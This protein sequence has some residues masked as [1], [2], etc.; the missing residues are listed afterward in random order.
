MFHSST[1]R[2]F[3]WALG[4]LLFASAGTLAAQG[5]TGQANFGTYVALG[6]S[7]TA[8]FMSGGLLDAVQANSYPALIHRQATGAG[9][10]QQP[11][12]AAPG[13]PP[14]LDLVRL[15]PTVIAPRAAS[16]GPPTN[17]T[18]P[19]PYSNLAIPGFKVGEVLRVRR[20]SDNGNRLV[21][22]I[23]RN[24][25]PAFG[26][27]TMLQQA[28]A[29]RPTFVSLWI[30]NNDV[31]GAATS[32]I[33]I[34]GVTLTPVAQ[35]DADY[36]A[37][38][39][40][41][42]AAG[43][44]LVLATIPNVTSIP[45]VTTIPSIL[46]N[47][48]TNQPVLVNGQPVPLIGPNGPLTAADRVLL[49]ATTPLSQGIGIPRAAGGSGKPLPTQFFLDAAEQQAIASRVA[50]YNDIIRSVASANGAALVDINALFSNIA[51]RGVGFGGIS[52]TA[53]FLTGGIFS[54]DGVHPTPFGYAFLANEFIKAINR[55][56][57][58]R[59]AQVDLFPFT[60][61]SEGSA[62]TLTDF[63]AAGALFSNKAAESLRQGLN[64]P[65]TEVLL[66]RLNQRPNRPAG[67]APAPGPGADD[68]PRPA[69][70][71]E[72]GLE[73]EILDRQ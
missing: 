55:Q 10:F 21:D 67:P 72:T 36:R 7:L 47:P 61:G 59:I 65:P 50:A 28:I 42:R 31:L 34:D 26:N 17:L 19:R 12:F 33:V 66:A 45:F 15:L 56:Y 2:L 64:V 58:G 53:A 52:Y 11:T 62:G 57:G 24:A 49:T 51:A 70:G 71:D 22:P 25:N 35:F 18:L 5:N 44:N 29:Q 20:T 46:V 60:F 8:G 37:I 30:G 9:G 68:P 43:A 69:A 6:D 13:A 4:A 48:A 27:T 38:V 39:A 23:L 73:R 1:R 3:G 14:L 41:L 54:Y 16:S 63:E 40:A 32:G